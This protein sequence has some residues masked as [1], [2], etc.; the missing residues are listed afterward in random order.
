MTLTQDNPFF[1]QIA[2]AIAIGYIAGMARDLHQSPL[3]DFDLFNLTDEADLLLYNLCFNG[4]S[5]LEAENGVEIEGRT[6]RLKFVFWSS[7]ANGEELVTGD[8]AL[9]GLVDDV[10]THCALEMARAS[11]LTRPQ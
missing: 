5:R 2:N 10:Q 8:T 11:L 9:H 1:S 3:A 7:D 6:Y 4:L